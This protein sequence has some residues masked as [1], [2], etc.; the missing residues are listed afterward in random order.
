MSI[1]INDAVRL[2]R[3][4]EFALEISSA[5]T[6]YIA[7]KDLS[8]RRKNHSLQYYHIKDLINI[9]IHKEARVVLYDKKKVIKILIDISDD[10]NM[11]MLNMITTIEELEE[12]IL[13]NII[14]DS[15]FYTDMTNCY[16]NRFKGLSSSKDFLPIINWMENYKL[17]SYYKEFVDKI[18]EKMYEYFL[19]IR[20]IVEDIYTAAEEAIEERLVTE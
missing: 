13:R 3:E 5:I 15:T 19:A 18:L 20:E 9:I 6:M 11:Y 4:Y 16:Y 1:L 14:K 2:V 12:P 7:N 17:E 8:E 10:I